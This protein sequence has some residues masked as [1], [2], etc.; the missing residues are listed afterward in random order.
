MIDFSSC[1][2]FSYITIINGNFGAFFNTSVYFIRNYMSFVDDPFHITQT[3]NYIIQ[4]K[5]LNISCFSCDQNADVYGIK[6]LGQFLIAYNTPSFGIFDFL[7]KKEK[8]KKVFSLTIFLSM[9]L[10]FMDFS[11]ILCSLLLITL[12]TVKFN[13]ELKNKYDLLFI[14]KF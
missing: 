14:F 6:F 3:K 4:F 8:K 10:M 5:N 2:Y 7:L 11:T 12:L 9:G 1:I 13:L